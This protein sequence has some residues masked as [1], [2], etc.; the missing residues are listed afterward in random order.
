MGLKEVEGARDTYSKMRE[1]FQLGASDM[2]ICCAI[3][4]GWFPCPE[5]NISIG[6]VPLTSVGPAEIGGVM[7]WLVKARCGAWRLASPL[8]GI[9]AAGF[10]IALKPGLDRGGVAALDVGLP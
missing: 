4:A 9:G 3:V 7:G 10:G 8:V 2:D 1:G 5:V 6:C